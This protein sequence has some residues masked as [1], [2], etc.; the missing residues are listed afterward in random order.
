[1]R[2][3]DFYLLADHR[4]ENELVLFLIIFI[5]VIGALVLPFISRISAFFRNGFSFA[6]IALS[7]ALS[8]LLLP[9][10]LKNQTISIFKDLPLGFNFFLSADSLAVYMAIVASFISALIVLYSFDYIKHY[11]NQN[12]YYSMVVLFL[13]AMMGL[14]FSANL[15]FLYVFWE[16]TAVTSWRLIG[17]FRKKEHILRAD[18][19]FLMTVFGS[20]LMLLGFIR[21]YQETGSFDLFTIKEAVKL[22]PISNL[23]IALILAG[24]FSK[25]ATLPFHTWLPDAGVA[26]SPVTALL[27]AAVLVKI[28]VYVFARIFVANIP[29]AVFWQ[30]V[31][32]AIAGLSALI[33]AGAAL[34]ET[35]LKR[36]IAYSTISQIGFIFLGFSI[37]NPV[38]TAGAILF[39]LMHGLAKAGLFLCAGIVEQ[40]AKTKDIRQ[41]GGLIQTMPVTALSFLFCAFSVMSIPP[42]G[43]F[44]SKYMVIS[45]ALESGHLIIC[46]VFLFGALLT[47][48][49]LFRVF[50]MVF[51]GE[52]RNPAR[53]G[54]FLMLLCVALFAA[55][56]LAGGIFIKYP[57]E[58][59]QTITR[60]LVSLR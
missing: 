16:I 56:S 53:E 58:I 35:D 3:L 29:L 32:P 15:I 54:S 40:N 38:G 52:I 21:I 57:N 48:L 37:G 26:P 18:K 9:S 41:L 59:V 17:F 47:I 44:F 42:F 10:A 55:L 1:M 45:G 24:I 39:I 19:A 7:C 13:G 49:Y 5:P 4:M 12:E 14:V 46:A 33:S 20:L 11:E 2:S 43:G 22:H 28:G 50:N 27:H 8:F 30:T 60:Q 6:V 34:M 25:S 51:L 36:I 31:I 23:T